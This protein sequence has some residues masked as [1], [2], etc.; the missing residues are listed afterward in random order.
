M[1]TSGEITEAFGDQ[2]AEGILQ[3]RSSIGYYGC[4]IYE[5]ALEIIG[6]CPICKIPHDIVH[7]I[8]QIR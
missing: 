5:T 2:L 3:I 4:G 1:A 6:F 7:I 8:V